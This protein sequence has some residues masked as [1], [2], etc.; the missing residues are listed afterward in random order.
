MASPNCDLFP[1][2][3]RCTTCLSRGQSIG[4][5]VAT[6]IGVISTLAVLS[7]FCIVIKNVLLYKRH[8]PST[9]W[10]LFK[11]PLDVYMAS[12]LMFDLFQ[13]VGKVLHVK[14]LNNGLVQCSGYCTAQGIIQQIGE[15]GVAQSTLAIAVHTFIIIFFREGTKAIRTSIIVVTSIWLFVF[16]FSITGAAT[17]RDG[18]NRYITPTP[19]WCWINEQ[20]RGAQVA[21]EYFWMWLTATVSLAVYIP[22]YLKLAGYMEAIWT[23][24]Q[25]WQFRIA[26]PGRSKENE[27]LIS[28]KS[29]KQAFFMLLY[30]ISYFCLVLPDS[31]VRWITFTGERNVPTSATFFAT[32]VFGLSGL[33]NVALL[34]FGRPGL[35]LLNG[36][37]PESI[38]EQPWQ[39]TN[40]S[41]LSDKNIAPPGLRIL[42]PIIESKE[43]F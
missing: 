17:L 12:L 33:V 13:G 41:Q 36:P 22:L 23:G 18:D 10:R 19:F 2:G 30:P 11:S 8:V 28:P 26:R 29:S 37:P 21:G 4:L 31:I 6:V 25:W 14:W 35:L 7:V 27:I 1:P 32:T 5:T 40:L 38:P 16:V 42:H 43:E 3:E 15:T 39:L 9:E 20:H 24:T 34:H